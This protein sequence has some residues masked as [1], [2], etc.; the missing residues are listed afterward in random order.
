MRT[1]VLINAL[2]IIV[3]VLVGVWLLGRAIDQ[4]IDEIM[5][6]CKDG[7]CIEMPQQP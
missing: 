2:T 3:V 7:V 1:H 4:R 5:P 6:P